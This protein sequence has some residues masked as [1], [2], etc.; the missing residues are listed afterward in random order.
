M[1]E[2]VQLLNQLCDIHLNLSINYLLNSQ[3]L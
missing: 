1:N 3:L 2:I